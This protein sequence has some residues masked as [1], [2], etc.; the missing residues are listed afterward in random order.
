MVRDTGHLVRV[1]ETYR[2]HRCSLRCIHI[3]GQVRLNTIFHGPPTGSFITTMPCQPLMA[4]I[5]GLEIAYYGYVRS[6][7][8][9]FDEYH[10]GGEVEST[11]ETRK[12]SWKRLIEDHKS[13]NSGETIDHLLVRCFTQTN[14]DVSGRCPRRLHGL[15]DS[16]KRVVRIEDIKRG[17][18]EEFLSGTSPSAHSSATKQLMRLPVFLFQLPLKQVLAEPSS[19]HSLTSLISDLERKRGKRFASGYNPDLRPNTAGPDAQP[20]SY[21]PLSVQMTIA[22]GWLVYTLI[23]ISRIWWHNVSSSHQPAIMT[24]SSQPVKTTMQSEAGPPTVYGIPPILASSTAMS[25][26]MSNL[27]CIGMCAAPPLRSR[28][29]SRTIETVLALAAIP[30]SSLAMMSSMS[31]LSSIGMCAAPPLR[32]RQRSRTMTSVVGYPSHS[33]FV[34]TLRTVQQHIECVK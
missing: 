6:S 8:H 30:A 2:S 23:Q 7:L 13:R 21:T 27:S 5:L 22:V 24:E 26:S 29:R 33:P 4:A 20:L 17:N 9:K 32:T 14:F 31:N 15:F 10:H 34:S 1:A 25:S 28:Q 16:Q 11:L 12:Y 18:M 19:H 3:D